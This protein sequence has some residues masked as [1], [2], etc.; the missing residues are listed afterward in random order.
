VQRTENG[1][2]S[3]GAGTLALSGDMK[4]MNPEYV[5]GLSLKGYGASLALGVG[6]PIPILDVEMLRH[7]LVRDEEIFGEVIDYSEDYPQKTG[8]VIAKVNYGELRTGEVEIEGKKVAVSSMSS[9]SK[10][11][12]IAEILKEEIRAGDFLI[13]SPSRSLPLNKTMGSLTIHD[14]E[15]RDKR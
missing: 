7:T 3:E 5:K 8:R 14:E 6:I 13:S 2:P 15:G 11:Q 1:V 10:A 12:S 4:E 9:Y